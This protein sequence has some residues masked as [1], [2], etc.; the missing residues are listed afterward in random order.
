MTKEP[1]VPPPV[2]RVEIRAGGHE[3]VVEAAAPLT[4]VRKT[5]LDL[6]RATDSPQVTRSVSALGFFAE[7]PDGPLPPDLT[8]PEPPGWPDER[9]RSRIT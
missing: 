5:A 8:I 7:R 9:C 4:T 1:P 3:V 2:A 6:F